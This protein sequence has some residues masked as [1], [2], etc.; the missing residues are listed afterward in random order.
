MKPILGREAEMRIGLQADF[1]TKAPAD[2]YTCVPFY[3]HDIGASQPLVDDPLLGCQDQT[4]DPSEPL[5]D[6]ISHA[7]ALSV[8]LELNTIGYW[9][10]GLL[11]L[12]VT[13][14]NGDGTFT[15]IFASG[16]DDLPFQTI[17]VEHAAD[18]LSQ[19]IGCMLN[20]MNIDQ[21]KAGGGRRINFDVVGK[22]EKKLIASE[23]GAVDPSPFVKAA[24]VLA[25]RGVGSIDGAPLT[26]ARN[27][28]LAYS[29]NAAT[30]ESMNDSAEAAGQDQ[31]ETSLTGNLVA[32]YVDD[33]LVDI[34]LD[35]TPHA[36]S[37]LF[38]LGNAVGSMLIEMPAVRFTRTKRPINGPGNMELDL[39]F[40][41]H[42]K[43]DTS[44]PM[45]TITLTNTLAAYV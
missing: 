1:D 4:L 21:T 22:N 32:R 5:D 11:G 15:H 10:R 36:L 17:E 34:G 37:L 44:S 19:H 27:I 2:S 43:S 25:F 42:Y 6:L 35:K 40:Q 8:P 39:T 28:R 7:G 9:L 24:Q 31:G 20:G 12:P 14:D 41:G 13:A 3:S 23:A 18:K 29:N 30:D 16:K 45:M 33:A 38:D 26:V